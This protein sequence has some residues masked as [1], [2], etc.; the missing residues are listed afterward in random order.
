M[1]DPLLRRFK[2]R[3]LKRPAS[4]L[5]RYFSPFFFTVGAFAL[6]CAA[7]AFVAYG[8]RIPSLILWIVSRICDGLD[9]AVARHKGTQSNFGGYVDFMLDVVVYT[10]LPLA[11]A[12]AAND[13]SIY[14][15]TALLF[16]AYYLNAVSW[17]TI[18]AL[19]E[20]QRHTAPLS[21]HQHAPTS[22]RMPTGIMEGAE[23][24]VLYG[25]ICILPHHLPL[26]FIIGA[27]LAFGGTI[28]RGLWV[29]YNRKDIN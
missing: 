23:T 28:Q 8:Y 9:G 19:L 1:F 6:G 20:K 16:A 2:A 3:L 10:L 22:L 24:I 7:A 17:L 15:V 25:L 18:S 13:P 12:T 14:R 27:V 21:P 11:A 4:W 5:S 29:F 26:L